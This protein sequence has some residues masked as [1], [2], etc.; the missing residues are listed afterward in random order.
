MS[1]PW[2]LPLRTSQQASPARHILQELLLAAWAHTCAMPASHHTDLQV[3]RIS[4]LMLLS[5]AAVTRVSLSP[6][7][8]RWWLSPLCLSSGNS[9]R[10]PWRSS[11]PSM[12]R[13]LVQGIL[14]SS[15]HQSSSDCRC[16]LQ[17][18]V[19]PFFRTS[20]W[21]NL[22]YQTTDVYL[23]TGEKQ[24]FSGHNCISKKMSYL[25]LPLLSPPH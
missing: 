16:K 10:S 17:I 6:C 9:I 24:T 13:V 18:S 22:V 8:G 23:S 20:S 12:G 1:L 15:R 5:R 2:F 11:K 14:P 3:R 7:N 21:E 25:C 4:P 19:F